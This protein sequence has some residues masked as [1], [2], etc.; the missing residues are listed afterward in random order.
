MKYVSEFGNDDFIPHF[1]YCGAFQYQYGNRDQMSPPHF[2]AKG[3]ISAS[4]RNYKVRSAIA[5]EL[6]LTRH[7]L[8]SK[9]EVKE[10][11][12]L[13]DQENAKFLRNENVPR[14]RIS[15]NDALESYYIDLHN[16]NRKLTE[17]IAVSFLTQKLTAK[18]LKLLD[19]REKM[20]MK[21][22]MDYSEDFAIRDI[23]YGL[24]KFNYDMEQIK[25]SKDSHSKFVRSDCFRQTYILQSNEEKLD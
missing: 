25:K 9:E 10:R 23:K 17:E 3:I 7:S 6:R 18:E 21:T 5:T 4:M 24:I 16:S 11:Y 14:P 19:R 12:I 13:A 20:F 22:F 8:M 1:I 2:D 15:V